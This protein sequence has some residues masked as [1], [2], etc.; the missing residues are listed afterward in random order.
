M[1]TSIL[2][3]LACLISFM[4]VSCVNDE[5]FLQEGTLRVTF[6]TSSDIT[7]KTQ[8]TVEVMD[9]TDTP[10][11]SKP[12]V[13]ENSVGRR[14]IEVKLNT[15]NYKVRTSIGFNIDLRGIQIRKDRT[16]EI[17]Y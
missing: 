17:K 7:P 5:D 10:G 12:I 9:F 2:F 14:P 4:F 11:T 3:T 1:K 8:V 16:T 15:G 13:T 6:K